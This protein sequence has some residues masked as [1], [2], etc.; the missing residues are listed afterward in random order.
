MMPSGFRRFGHLSFI[1]QFSK[2]NIHWPQQPPTER[3]FHD[4]FHKNG[5]DLIIWVLGIIQP[6]GSVIFWWIEA[7]EVIEVTE[8]VE[9]VEVIEAGKVL[10]PGISLLMTAESSRSLN[11]TLCW[12]FENKYFLLESWNIKLNFGPF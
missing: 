2:S 3:D 1:N 4:P 5:L 9:A 12:C 11:I 6:S 7:V 10:R 8:V